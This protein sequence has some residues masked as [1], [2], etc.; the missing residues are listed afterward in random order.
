M[1][2][3]ISIRFEWRP[4]IFE[5]RYLI[6]LLKHSWWAYF[7]LRLWPTYWIIRIWTTFWI[8]IIDGLLYR[9]LFTNCPIFKIRSYV[10]F[11]LTF[12]SFTEAPLPFQQHI[13]H[14][15]LL[16]KLLSIAQILN[17]FIQAEIAF[18]SISIHKRPCT[19]PTLHRL[20]ASI[21]LVIE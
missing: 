2:I 16:F 4:F 13:S 6:L 17:R 14:V 9:L 5:N 8:L 7:Y 1:K 19:F 18:R 15:L 3:I 12:T 21:V 10:E 11:S 20:S